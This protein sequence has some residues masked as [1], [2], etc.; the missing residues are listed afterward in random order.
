[1]WQE[2]SLPS[3]SRAYA[4]Y[5]FVPRDN[6]SNLHVSSPHIL[7]FIVDSGDTARIIDETIVQ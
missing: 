7:I 5:T 6:C 4:T 3:T 1:M 2:L